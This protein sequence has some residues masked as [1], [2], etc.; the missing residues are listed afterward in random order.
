MLRISTVLYAIGMTLAISQV[1]VAQTPS[2]NSAS[3]D[4]DAQLVDDKMVRDVDAE[5]K[6]IKR[7]C[8]PEEIVDDVVPEDCIKEPIPVYVPV[9]PPPLL[10]DE[11]Q[12]TTPEEEKAKEAARKK[13]IKDFEAVKS[14]L[15]ASLIDEHQEYQMEFPNR[16]ISFSQYMYNDFS[17]ERRAGIL[18]IAIGV[19]IFGGLTALGAVML[20]Q[21]LDDPCLDASLSECTAPQIRDADDKKSSSIFLLALGASGTIASVVVGAIKYKRGNEPLKK[22][23]PILE[24]QKSDKSAIHFNGFAPVVATSDAIAPGTHFSFSF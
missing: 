2:D 17:K 23:A 18:F 1:G 13:A 11:I 22:L 6:E 9:E 8:E 19:P 20:K 5:E 3:N 14:A 7:I 24:N 21:N 10:S 12:Y 4:V 15:G 16:S